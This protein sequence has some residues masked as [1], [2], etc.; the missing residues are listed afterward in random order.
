MSYIPSFV[1]WI[2]TQSLT[3][4]LTARA[5]RDCYMYKGRAATTSSPR[6]I[7]RSTSTSSKQRGTLM[8]NVP[9]VLRFVPFSIIINPVYNETKA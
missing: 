5:R 6:R 4:K 7:R 2:N 3:T 1:V 9:S 8:I